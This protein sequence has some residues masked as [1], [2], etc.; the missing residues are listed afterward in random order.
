MKQK[1]LLLSLIH[2]QLVQSADQ[3]PNTN[4]TPISSNK[5]SINDVELKLTQELLEALRSMLSVVQQLQE[6]QLPN[7][8]PD[9]TKK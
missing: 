8:S 6:Q 1:L 3:S 2:L 4:T 9:A 7:T 5:P